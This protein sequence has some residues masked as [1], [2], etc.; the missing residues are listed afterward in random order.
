MAYIACI[1][2]VCIDY[3]IAFQIAREPFALYYSIAPQDAAPGEVSPRWEDGLLL[4][5]RRACPE[6]DP[7]G[8]GSLRGAEID[9]LLF[10]LL[11]ARMTSSRSYKGI[12]I[13]E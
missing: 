8:S 1:N 7:R 6:P 13:R 11:G 5:G 12:P 9:V 4:F 3:Q 10:S 2:F